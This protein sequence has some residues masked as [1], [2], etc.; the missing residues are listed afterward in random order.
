MGAEVSGIEIGVDTLRIEGEPTKLYEALAAAQAEFAPV[1]KLDEGQVGMSRKFKYAGYATLMKCVRPALTKH[2]I[3]LIQP[4]HYRDGKAVTTTILAGH[5]ASIQTSYSFN[6]DYQRKDKNG[7]VTDDC[8]EFGRSHTYYR[9][10][11]LQSILGI[12]GDDDA[13]GL[14][15]AKQDSRQFSEPARDATTGEAMP[16][17]KEPKPAAPKANGA[18]AAPKPAAVV[19]QT[20]PS[21]QAS[22]S[23][24][25]AKSDAAVPSAEKIVEGIPPEKLNTALTN[26][27]QQMTPPWL[28]INIREFYAKHFDAENEMP[29][30]QD[31]DPTLKR[32]ILAKM[33][34]VEKVAPF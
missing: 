17:K 5:G 12:E 30:P 6:A 18:S 33:I 3:A 4:L 7:T 29:A 16:P 20:L 24:T 22:D 10:Y 31:M 9:R 26:C 15:E 2:G 32:R 19:Q 13:D 27:M 34:E 25:A 8:Q 21:V 28:V 23:T 11:Q 1:P 14:P